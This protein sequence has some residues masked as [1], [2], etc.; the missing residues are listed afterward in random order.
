MWHEELQVQQQSL[1]PDLPAGVVADLLTEDGQLVARGKAAIDLRDV[2]A[3]T[4]LLRVH[5]LAGNAEADLPFAVSID[6]PIQG[7]THQDSDRDRIL[8]AVE[9][10]A[11]LTGA[12]DL[13]VT[14][15][16]TLA[17][18]TVAQG[19]NSQIVFTS[20]ESIRSA[21]SALRDR[22][23]YRGQ[24]NGVMNPAT[25]EVR[26]GDR[27][28]EL[29]AR[30]YDL[31]EFLTRHARQVFSRETIFERVWGSDY[32]GESNVIDVHVS[33]LR[34][35]LG[36]GQVVG[37]SVLHELHDAAESERVERLARLMALAEQVWED[38]T[39]RGM[40]RPLPD[41]L[42]RVAERSRALRDGS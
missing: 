28:I 26:R 18:T 1:D 30:E 31:L 35:K 8:A 21:Q 5:N 11:R 23:Y 12:N 41:F 32:M 29:T 24:I 36:E 20:A 19:G 7:A 6:P 39:G 9:Q 10:N 22:G 15:A 40:V 17:M 33:R 27:A 25:R 34:R 3:G 38:E 42:Q 2:E 13:K 4:Y 14:A 16:A 37:D